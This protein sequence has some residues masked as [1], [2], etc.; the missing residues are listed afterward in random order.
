MCAV[1]GISGCGRNTN[2]SLR[3]SNPASRKARSVSRLGWQPPPSW[4]H[5]G[6]I[7]SWTKPPTQAE[8]TCS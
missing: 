5:N 8:R 7:R 2:R 6:V 1:F 4:A 3:T